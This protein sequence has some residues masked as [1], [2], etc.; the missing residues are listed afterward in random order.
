MEHETMLTSDLD[1][2]PNQCEKLLEMH[3]EQSQEC[4]HELERWPS[5]QYSLPT[6]DR[7]KAE[8]NKSSFLVLPFTYN[9]T[10]KHS[11]ELRIV[12]R[13]AHDQSKESLVA[14]KNRGIEAYETVV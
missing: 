12:S 9:P 11:S 5:A 7:G 6:N 14:V 1:F 4:I 10:Q 3:L 8:T 2:K 13:S